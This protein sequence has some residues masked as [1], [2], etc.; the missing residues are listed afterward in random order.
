MNFKSIKTKILLTVIALFLV[1]IALMIFMTNDKTKKES[2]DDVYESSTNILREASYSIENFLAQY[3]KGV[4]LLSKEDSVTKFKGTADSQR[5]ERQ[6]L[7]KLEEFLGIYGDASSA[8]YSLPSKKT[9]I[10]PVAELGDFDATTRSWYQLAE[11]NPDKVQWS[12]PYVDVATGEFV[13]T[14]SKAVLLNGKFT[15]VM[16]LDIKLNSLTQKIGASEIGYKGS[17]VLYDQ[18]GVAISHPTKSGENMMEIPYVKSLYDKESGDFKFTDDKGKKNVTVFRTL[19]DYGWKLGA[20]YYEKDLNA[21]SKTLRNS[22]F[23]IAFITLVIISVG[24][25][26]M[27]SRTIRPIADLKKLMDEASEGDLTVQSSIK[28][29]DEIGQL[30]QNFNKMIANMRSIISVVNVSAENVRASSESLSAVSEETSASSAEVAHAVGE[31]AEGASKSAEDTEVVTER[32]EQLGEQINGINERAI[33]MTSI[34]ESTGIMNTNGQKQMAELSETF[35]SS[36]INLQTMSQVIST[37]GEKVKAIGVVMETITTI[38]SQTNLLALNA[39]IEAARAGE[40]GKGFAVVA[41]EVRKLAEQSAKAT[42]DV[43]VTVQELQQESLTV[44]VQME[45]TIETFRSQGIVVGET[46]T[47]FQK[48]SEMM[49]EMQLSIDSISD[50]I[51]D[52][53]HHKDEVSLT[54]QTLAAT[55]E[56]T[57][58]ACEEVSASTEEQL[59]AIHSVTDAA[60]TL[61]E[62]S[63]ELTN[64]ISRFHV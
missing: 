29:R 12:E 6:L 61:T 35:K 33:Q 2:L 49:K 26:I 53:S 9:I 36:G 59:R 24:L 41:E 25:Y 4:E 51:K 64:A 55:S 34:A 21:L 46:E 23:V 22:M 43:K 62:L 48:L 17:L 19:P 60:E 42:E 52:V 8:Y 11:A 37:L 14:A 30:G 16:G 39:S 45:E 40:H 3:G 56:E 38:S 15:G 20:V 32:T 5:E 18:T 50:E 47:T 63:E 31:I 13:I 58:A 28:S 44:T 57:A 7:S 54:V 1:G 27:I 10:Y